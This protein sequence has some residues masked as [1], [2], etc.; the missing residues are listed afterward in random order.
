SGAGCRN[1]GRV[2]LHRDVLQPGA[3]PWFRWRRRTGRVRKALR[4]KR[5]MSVYETLGGP[6][7]A[8]SDSS[9]EVLRFA[10]RYRRNRLCDSQVV[11]KKPALPAGFWPHN[12][13]MKLEILVAMGGI[14]S[15]AL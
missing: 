14:M 9:R 2:R 12:L 5:P 10:R 3:S 11:T 4:A 15:L 6:V 8:T 13:L 1:L 7:T